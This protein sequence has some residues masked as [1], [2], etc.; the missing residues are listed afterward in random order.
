MYQ[1]QIEKPST[2][3]FCTPKKH[4][5]TDLVSYKSLR[6]KMYVAC[7]KIILVPAV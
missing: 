2:F 7:V 4:N 5:Q 3:E 1:D 6:I